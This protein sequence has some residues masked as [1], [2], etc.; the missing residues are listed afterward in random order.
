MKG[1]RSK[2]VTGKRIS[3]RTGI[4]LFTVAMLTMATVIVFYQNPL[5]NPQDERIKKLIACGIILIAIL[6]FAC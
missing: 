1:D 2:E 3:K 4:I 5:A 6:G